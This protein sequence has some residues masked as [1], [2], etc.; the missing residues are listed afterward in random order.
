MLVTEHLRGVCPVDDLLEAQDIDR[1]LIVA[2]WVLEQLK[3]R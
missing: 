3:D 1:H 2:D